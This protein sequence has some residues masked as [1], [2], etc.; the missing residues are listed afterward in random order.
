M[1]PSIIFYNTARVSLGC[2]VR[3]QD[4]EERCV[5]PLFCVWCPRQLPQFSHLMRC[6]DVEAS[7]CRFPGKEE[8]IPFHVLHLFLLLLW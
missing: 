5:C 4:P 8:M 1:A 3:R 7:A 2:K 6:A